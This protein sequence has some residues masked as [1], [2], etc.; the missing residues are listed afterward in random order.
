MPFE[1]IFF[2]DSYLLICFK[3]NT[4]IMSWILA[5]QISKC[6]PPSTN[7]HN[8]AAAHVEGPQLLVCRSLSSHH[9]SIF[10]TQTWKS[11]M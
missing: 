7:K 4:V 5:F 11:E 10:K 1:T 6:S 2:P 8:Q 3:V 9:A